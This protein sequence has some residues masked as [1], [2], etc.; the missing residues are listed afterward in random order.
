MD[1]GEKLSGEEPPERLQVLFGEG[2][3]GLG[4][5][6]S[7]FAGGSRVLLPGA[8]LSGRLARVNVGFGCFAGCGDGLPVK[9]QELLRPHAEGIQM[10]A[11]GLHRRLG[12]HAL[13]P[14]PC[15][16]PF[17]HE[18]CD[19]HLVLVLL[20]RRVFQLGRFLVDPVVP[21]VRVHLDRAELRLII[22]SDRLQPSVMLAP[23]LLALGLE[24]RFD[25]ALGPR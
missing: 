8:G 9:P 13:L 12:F 20:L 21:V 16:G 2:L 25:P 22:R 6:R 23:G 17:G 3:L 4:T 15:R 11:C 24:V 5:R 19:H 14:D 1:A 10:M 7:C 18:V